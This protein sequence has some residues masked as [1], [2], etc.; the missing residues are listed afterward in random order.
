[1]RSNDATKRPSLD[2]GCYLCDRKASIEPLKGV[3]GQRFDVECTGDCP[4]Y[5]IT[6]L[7][8]EYLRNHPARRKEAIENI[9]RIAASGTFPV[10][11]TI[12]N[13]KQLILTSRR[14]E[15]HDA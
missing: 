13:P 14:A 12:G 4:R 7:A 1:M 11:R 8:K 9:R 6:R 10:L 2:V 3:S 15:K 5:E